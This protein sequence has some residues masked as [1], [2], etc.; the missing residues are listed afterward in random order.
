L[1]LCSA[2]GKGT[3]APRRWFRET[4]E[5]ARWC[6]RATAAR[7]GL[8]RAGN[9]PTI[10]PLIAM[11]VNMQQNICALT[12]GMAGGYAVQTMLAVMGWH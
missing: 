11:S 12:L 4:G 9:R 10:A 2:G 6:H 7:D 8:R 1:I 5:F 3:I